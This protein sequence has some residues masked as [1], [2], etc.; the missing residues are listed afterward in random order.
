MY[1]RGLG[2]GARGIAVPAEVVG[3]YEAYQKFGGKLSWE[4]IV[5]PTIKIC[6]DGV[7]VIQYVE[8]TIN[9][10]KD[11]ILASKSLR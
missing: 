8:N 3:Y 6:E 5:E 1:D 4:Q 9:K 7:P 10:K 11:D 2:P